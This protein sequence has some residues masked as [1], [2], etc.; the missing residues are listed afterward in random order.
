MW[1]PKQ[2]EFFQLQWL[3]A[4]REAIFKS[5]ELPDVHRDPFDRLLAAQAI[6]G[7]FKLI[8]PDHPFRDLGVDCLW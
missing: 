1:I 6:V 2:V 4:E 5:G 8:S 7:S 3:P